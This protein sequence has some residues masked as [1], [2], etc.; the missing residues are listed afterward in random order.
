MQNA[1]NFIEKNLLNFIG[2]YLQ[3]LQ[4]E[5]VIFITG[6]DE[7]GEKISLAAASNGRTPKEHCD[8]VAEDY[9]SLWKEVKTQLIH[10]GL[11]LYPNKKKRK[12]S[13]GNKNTMKVDYIYHCSLILVMIGSYAQPI[14]AMKRLQSCSI[15][16][17]SR[18]VIYTE[19]IMR[20]FTVLIV[21]SLRYDSVF[22]FSKTEHILK[23]QSRKFNYGPYVKVLIVL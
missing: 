23:G 12:S 16:K 6:T 9:R 15:R 1:R 17:Y 8:L 11:R 3:R 4:G 18:G 10:L 22:F 19:L 7:H 21:R 14:V 13:L 5:D 20:G 2:C